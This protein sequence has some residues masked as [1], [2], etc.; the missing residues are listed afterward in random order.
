MQIQTHAFTSH[1]LL[2]VPHLFLPWASLH[3]IV[4][5]QYTVGCCVCLHPWLFWLPPFGRFCWLYNWPLFTLSSPLCN[6]VQALLCTLLA[7]PLHWPTPGLCSPP[8]SPP[9]LLH[10][11]DCCLLFTLSCLHWVLPY[12]GLLSWSPLATIIHIHFLCVLNNG[13]PQS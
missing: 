10:V 4:S 12:G 1:L 6:L 9:L 5:S 7:P 11:P 8:S 2:F 13:W 3:F